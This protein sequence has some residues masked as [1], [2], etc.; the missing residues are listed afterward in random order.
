MSEP[1]EPM[2]VERIAGVR[3]SHIEPPLDQAWSNLEK[4]RWQAGVV[5]V[6]SGVSVD[7]GLA[8]GRR[9]MYSLSGDCWT[10]G[11]F[12]FHACWLYLNG[13]EKG[14]KLRAALDDPT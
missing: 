9:A 4:L 6:D 8:P 10:V 2:V 1:L 7:V 14:A 12:D 13:V 11:H 3:G 5:L